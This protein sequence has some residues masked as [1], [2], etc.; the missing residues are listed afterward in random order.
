MDGVLVPISVCVILPVAIVL[1]VFLAAMNSD[2][3]RA[4]ILIKAIESNNGVNT[5]K[6]AESLQRKPR[7]TPREV[8]NSRLLKGCI[9][10]LVG[11]FLAITGVVNTALGEINAGD[12]S[13][14]VLVI[15]GGV[16]LAVGISFLIVYGVTRRQVEASDNQAR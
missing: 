16:S 8:L 10:S 15:I 2:N 4:Q 6:L 1:I 7:K 12:D 13:V 14:S 3:K 11:L 9:F 5:D